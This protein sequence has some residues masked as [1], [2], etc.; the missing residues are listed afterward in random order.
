MGQEALLLSGILG[1]SALGGI[2]A[3]EGQKLQSFRDDGRTDP[4][5]VGGEVKGLLA[6]YLE[7]L[8][9]RAEEPITLRTTVNPNPAFVG[10]ALPFSVSA[11]GMDP[12]RINPELRTRHIN[13]SAT[14]ARRRLELPDTTFNP[15]PSDEE[16]PGGSSSSRDLDAALGA[17]DLLL[18]QVERPKR[19]LF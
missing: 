14:F 3:P 2:F 8:Q 6:D 9:N 1:G 16:G 7:Y 12:N 15:N 19:M 17:S 13:P 4:V 5:T 11:P 18:A 10:G